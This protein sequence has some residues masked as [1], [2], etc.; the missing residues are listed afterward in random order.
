M[1]T[2]GA[3]FAQVTWCAAFERKKKK[4]CLSKNVDPSLFLSYRPL[5]LRGNFDYFFFFLQIEKYRERLKFERKR[6]DKVG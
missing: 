2:L 1:C 5:S 4:K 6:L 3:Q